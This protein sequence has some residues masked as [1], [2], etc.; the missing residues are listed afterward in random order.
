MSQL[1][2]PHPL[3]HLPSKRLP[4]PSSRQ[5]SQPATFRAG[6][7]S[8]SSGLLLGNKTLPLGV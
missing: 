8:L 2:A 1:S 7:C 3:A 5:A 4:A 6:R